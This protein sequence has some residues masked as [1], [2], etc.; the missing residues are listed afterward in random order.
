MSKEKLSD[1]DCIELGLLERV[2]S[3]LDKWGYC[4]TTPSWVYQYV[5]Q[6]RV[7]S[8]ASNPLTTERCANWLRYKHPEIAVTLG[9]ADSIKFTPWTSGTTIYG[10]LDLTGAQYH[11]GNDQNR[12]ALDHPN[13]PP[14]MIEY[15]VVRFA[16]RIH[17][18]SMSI[19]SDVYLGED[20]SEWVRIKDPRLASTLRL[21]ERR[22]VRLNDEERLQ[23]PA[24]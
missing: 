10:Y 5:F 8:M 17:Y 20:F 22:A 23:I 4:V 3:E 21:G 14:S 13:C 16:H 19:S 7:K 24:A 11:D 6:C 12:I 9:L 18:V 1:K 2:E 15:A